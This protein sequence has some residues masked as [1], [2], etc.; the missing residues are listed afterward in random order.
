[1]LAGSLIGMARMAMGDHFASD[2]IWSAVMVY[3]C[4]WQ[5]SVVNFQFSVDK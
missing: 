2:V 4:A 5:L 1:L 3:S